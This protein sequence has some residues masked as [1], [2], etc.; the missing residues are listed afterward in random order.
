MV[1]I[2]YPI[3]DNNNP[4]P[5]KQKNV[6]GRFKPVPYPDLKIKKSR[7]TSGWWNVYIELRT[8]AE[9]RIERTDVL[10]PETKGPQEKVFIDQVTREMA[11]WTFEPGRSEIHVDVRFYVE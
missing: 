7:F 8:T 5:G 10:R 3:D 4:I 9:G 2:W 6:E 1:V 11:R